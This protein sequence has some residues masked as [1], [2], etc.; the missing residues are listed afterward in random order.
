[1]RLNMPRLKVAEADQHGSSTGARKQG[2]P[3]PA[4]GRRQPPK[5]LG[6]GRASRMRATERT[7]SGHKRRHHLTS[8]EQ[9]AII[10]RYKELPEG[11][12]QKSPGLDKIAADFNVAKQMPAKLV[13]RL[14]NEGKL[15]TRKGVGGRPRAM[16]LEKEEELKKVVK[17]HAYDL[18][19]RQIEEL[20]GIPS[21]TASRFMKEDNGWRLAGKSCKP[22]LTEA[23]VK[24]REAWAKKHKKNQ[25]KGHVDI[26][27]K[28]F[29]VYSHSGKLKLP[30]GV[31]K[32]RTPVKSKRFIGKVMSD[33]P[34]RHLQASRSRKQDQ[35]PGHPS[36]A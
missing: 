33:V 8:D 11:K 15:P 20:T 34:H 31:Q 22:Y 30:P 19:F 4:R 5:P 1:M 25:W 10:L 21:S 7:E 18:T 14:K 35:E 16:T 36:R 28:W 12:R 2:A 13:K 24:A 29:N 9:A 23:N 17:E 26:D 32:P 27:E 3:K 6:H